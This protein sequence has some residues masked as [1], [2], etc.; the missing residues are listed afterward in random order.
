MTEI[1]KACVIN[2]RSKI[3][4]Y[5]WINF[6]LNSEIDWISKCSHSSEINE[7]SMNVMSVTSMFIRAKNWNIFSK[8]LKMMFTINDLKS[9]ELSSILMKQDMSMSLSITTLTKTNRFLNSLQ[10]RASELTWDSRMLY[11]LTSC[12][13]S[14]VFF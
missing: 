10:F 14:K 7:S 13:W 3:L 11:V 5:E 9:N 8:L 1:Y 2:I 12:I 6:N 4:L